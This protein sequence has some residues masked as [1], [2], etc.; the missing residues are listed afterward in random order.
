MKLY[1]QPF[2]KWLPIFIGILLLFSSL[3]VAQKNTL[4]SLSQRYNQ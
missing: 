2:N 3:G 1:F 4:Y